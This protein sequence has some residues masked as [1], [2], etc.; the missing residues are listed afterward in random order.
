VTSLKLGRCAGVADPV[1]LPTDTAGAA[2]PLAR[3]FSV[4]TIRLR[5]LGWH[6]RRRGTAGD[7]AV[8]YGRHRSEWFAEEL[9]AAVAVA[10]RQVVPA[11]WAFGAGGRGDRLEDCLLRLE[12]AGGIGSC[13]VEKRELDQRVRPDVAD[14]LDGGVPSVGSC[15]APG[16]GGGVDGLLGPRRTAR[17]A[18]PLAR[19]AP[20]G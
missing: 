2:A 6:K 20:G 1:S 19:P 5:I 3:P 16:G 4:V 7:G 15:L 10:C 14:M 18:V 17:P 13:P 9:S 8:R 11:L 12:R